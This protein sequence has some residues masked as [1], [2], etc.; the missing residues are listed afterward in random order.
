MDIAGVRGTC[1]RQSAFSCSVCIC[2]M[3]GERTLLW[4]A[5]RLTSAER[6]GFGRESITSDSVLSSHLALPALSSW[7]RLLLFLRLQLRIKRRGTVSPSRL[8]GVRRRARRLDKRKGACAL[9]GPGE[10]RCDGPGPV[11]AALCPGPGPAA[12]LE[13]PVGLGLVFGLL[14]ET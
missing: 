6:G 1:P 9:G 2:K 3:V 13:L 4:A 10:P 8:R 12:G 14:A 5:G 11:P 7:A